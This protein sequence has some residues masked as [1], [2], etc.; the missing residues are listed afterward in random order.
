MLRR[1]KLLPF[2]A[3]SN[4]CCSICLYGKTR[5][6]NVGL[7]TNVSARCIERHP[8]SCLIWHVFTVRTPPFSFRERTA[9]FSR[10]SVVA[11]CKFAAGNFAETT[12]KS[13][14]AKE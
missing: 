9:T 4:H 10:S 14:T 7:K 2:L 3:I 11:R 13:T 6:L 12:Y 1:Q 8:E 5:F